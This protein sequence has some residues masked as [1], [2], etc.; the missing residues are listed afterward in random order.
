MAGTSTGGEPVP[1][2]ESSGIWERIA[3]HADDIAAEIHK[4]GVDPDD[5]RAVWE[6]MGRRLTLLSRGARPSSRLRKLFEDMTAT[7]VLHVPHETEEVRTTSEESPE[8]RLAAE[9]V[10][11]MI[12]KLDLATATLEAQLAELRRMRRAA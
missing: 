8:E 3:A 10:D 6:A 12:A 5:A 11:R 7:E 9:A 4:G 1:M 2:A